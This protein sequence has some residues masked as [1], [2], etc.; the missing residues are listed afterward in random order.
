MFTAAST[1][2]KTIMVSEKPVQNDDKFED[3]NAS[4]VN[5]LRTV[6]QVFELLSIS[7][8]IVLQS[9]SLL[10]KPHFHTLDTLCH[11]FLN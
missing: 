3:V 6:N 11:I 10:A 4:S 9:F 1:F 5:I 8:L 2:Q 7:K